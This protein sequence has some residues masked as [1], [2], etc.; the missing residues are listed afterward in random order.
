MESLSVG[1]GTLFSIFIKTSITHDDIG[2][3]VI[4]VDCARHTLLMEQDMAL[5][6]NINSTANVILIRSR[7][8]LL[9]I[10]I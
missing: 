7:L 6:L 9:G 5:N 10:D 1:L 2:N 8:T 3:D 4:A